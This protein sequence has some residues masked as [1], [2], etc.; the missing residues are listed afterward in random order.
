MDFFFYTSRFFLCV[1]SCQVCACVCMYSYVLCLCSFLFISIN[2]INDNCSPTAYY[3]RARCKVMYTLLFF[4]P[5]AFFDSF[6]FFSIHPF[7][8]GFF[9]SSRYYTFV[10]IFSFHIIR[11]SIHYFFIIII[12]V[13]SAQ[14]VYYTDYCHYLDHIK[15]CIIHTQRS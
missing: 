6:H 11:F 13:W 5:L 4:L 8:F 3:I 12:N 1:S 7:I 9:F 15:I 14:M 10:C 2:A